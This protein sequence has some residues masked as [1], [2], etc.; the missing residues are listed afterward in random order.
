MWFTQ[1]VER[2]QLESLIQEV[3]IDIGRERH[4]SDSS[5]IFFSAQS[6][7]LSVL[8][9]NQLRY[10]IVSVDFLQLVILLGENGRQIV[11]VLHSEISMQVKKIE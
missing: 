3:Q 2:L 1:P 11:N 8:R 6:V 5:A 10:K 9:I 4:E 7:M